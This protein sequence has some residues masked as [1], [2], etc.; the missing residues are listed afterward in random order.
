M[1]KIK[2]HSVTGQLSGSHC[3][4]G[5]YYAS[6]SAYKNGKYL[7]N[8]EISG[9]ETPPDKYHDRGWWGGLGNDSV[10]KNI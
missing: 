7:R 9:G 10:T 4:S 1:K 8:L 2:E 6:H 5:C 3:G